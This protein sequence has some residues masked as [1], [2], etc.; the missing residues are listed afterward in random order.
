MTEVLTSIVAF[1]VVLSLLITVHEFGHYWVARKCGVKVLRFSVGFGSALWKRVAGADR[2]EYV[3]ATIP[4]GGYVKML[5]ER[6]GKV[7][8]DEL[9][10]A[11]NRQSVSRRTAIVAAGPLFNF[12]FAIVA[13]WLMFSIGVPGLKPLVDSV[14]VDS[15]AARS[16]LRGGDEIVAVDGKPTPTWQVVRQELLTRLLDGSAVTLDV[17]TASGASEQARIDLGAAG[18]DPQDARFVE[19]LGIR[20]I[21]V[22][23]P[24]QIGSVIRGQSADLAGMKAGDV[25]VSVDG[26]AVD[27]WGQWV[28]LVRSHP[29]Q[30]LI[31]VVERD[32]AR[33][34]LALRPAAEDE[35]GVRIGRIGAAPGSSPQVP[36][37]WKAVQRFSPVAA[38]GEA[39][40]KTWEMS[41]LTV[42]MLGKMVVGQ[43]S[44]ENLSGPITI[45]QYAGRTANIG[46]STFLAFLAIISVSL[47]VL[48]LLPIPM[49]DG[50]HIM[51]YLVE[52][53]TGRPLSEGTQI[54]LQR[55]GLV[56]LLLLMSLALYN[57]VAR[58][59]R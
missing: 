12:A 40:R 22:K 44:L 47:G 41:A 3:V 45:A 9:H 13:Y 8:P 31:V 5:D 42:V 51:Y 52:M 28:D 48:N 54:K 35:N 59:I 10:R 53:V 55:I 18:L 19:K 7:D 17:R 36:D 56:V 23:M 26:A 37:E 58:L 25:V 14:D 34:Q 16:G 20:A 1:I 11:F 21:A 57:D 46:F 49:L 33:V 6:E 2:T 43:V 27:D 32:G 50:G 24:A 38:V 29:E 39:I 30:E 4:L 15:V